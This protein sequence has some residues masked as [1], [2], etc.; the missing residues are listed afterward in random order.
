MRERDRH[1]RGGGLFFGG[2]LVL[3]GT[4]MLLSYLGLLGGH[5]VWDFW[6]LILVL[7]GL[8]KIVGSRRG[9]GRVF[10]VLLLGGGVLAQLHIL[11]VVQLE[12]RLV[13]P[14]GLILVGL[15]VLIGS[16]FRRRRKRPAPLSADM[17]DIKVV[18]GGRQERV[19]SQE[20]VG[21]R[22]QCTMSG[23]EL[24]LREARMKEDSATLEVRAVMGG[25]ELLV[26]RDWNVQVKGTPF[27]GAFEDK[28]RPTSRDGPLLV[29]EGDVL[30]GGVEIRN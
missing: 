21:G 18:F 27:M 2:L 8:F 10:G 19:D 30:M 6:P 4:L 12:W 16:L 9:G 26:P 17:L 13:W 15:L 14:V 5:G 3:A 20:F 29:I 11:D 25:V 28:T 1:P 24:D 22:I 23:C 7:A